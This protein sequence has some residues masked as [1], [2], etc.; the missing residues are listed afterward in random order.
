MKM[1]KRK[2]I[3]SSVVITILLIFG[4]FISQSMLFRQAVFYAKL[5][6]GRDDLSGLN[7]KQIYQI[8]YPKKLTKNGIR[9][10]VENE[11]YTGSREKECDK[12]SS[13]NCIPDKDSFV[14]V[15]L[16]IV[17]KE[18]QKNAEKYLIGVEAARQY[19]LKDLTLTEAEKSVREF[20]IFNQCYLNFS[21]DHTKHFQA[22]YEKSDKLK[23]LH[24]EEFFVV[25]KA[26]EKLNDINYNEIDES[27]E[28][29]FKGSKEKCEAFLNAHNK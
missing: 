22:V 21:K 19:F 24:P 27:V 25:M 8:K 26:D 11:L 2:L 12:D 17:K 9:P 13:G 4:Y 18:D 20:H 7:D 15:S 5:A 29:E 3:V 1:P 10:E 28:K 23:Y 14:G 16:G 6:T